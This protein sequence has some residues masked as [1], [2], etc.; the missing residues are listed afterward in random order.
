MSVFVTSFIGTIIA[1]AFFA[2]V[3]YFVLGLFISSGL[4]SFIAIGLVLW[5]GIP[6]LLRTL[7]SIIMEARGENV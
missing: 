2:A 3:I 7:R 6:P 5:A 4:A 1:M